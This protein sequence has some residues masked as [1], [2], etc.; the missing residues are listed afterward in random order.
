MLIIKIRRQRRRH[1]AVMLLF[2]CRLRRYAMPLCFDAAATA[3]PLFHYAAAYAIA[4]MP[5]L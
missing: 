4:E 5:L 2:I 1:D 3:M